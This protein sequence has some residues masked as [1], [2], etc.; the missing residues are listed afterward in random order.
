MHACVCLCLGECRCANVYTYKL[1]NYILL[2]WL[3]PLELCVSE[4]KNWWS[5][6]LAILIG[7]LA[8]LVP[9]LRTTLPGCAGGCC[10]C[11]CCCCWDSG[12]ISDNVPG[13]TVG[14]VVMLTLLLL[15]VECWGECPVWDGVWQG[16]QALIGDPNFRPRIYKTAQLGNYKTNTM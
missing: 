1:D 10:C 2:L 6:I 4:L 3:Q 5:R 7:L 8:F 9:C 11:C 15:A 16:S 13:E 12:C 14:V